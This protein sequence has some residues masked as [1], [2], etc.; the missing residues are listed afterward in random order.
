MAHPAFIE[1]IFPA[2]IYYL[3]LVSWA[4]GNFLLVYVTVMSVRV[5]KKGELLIPALLVPLYWVMMSMAAVKAVSQLVGA[6]N[7]WEKTVHGLHHEQQAE[8]VD[9]DIAA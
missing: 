5:A 2:P 1:E 8:P 3:G 9:A 7:F 4:F 6:P